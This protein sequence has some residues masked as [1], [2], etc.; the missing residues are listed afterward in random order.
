MA[1]VV[2]AEAALGALVLV[3]DYH[4]SLLGRMLAQ[5]RPD[6]HTVHFCHIPFA[7]PNML[8]VLP[9]HAVGELLAGLAG[10]GA[11]GF[12]A[13]RWAEGFRACFADADL[14]ALAGLAPSA[15]PPSFVSSL[16]PDQAGLRD[17][18]ASPA[19]ADSVER[20]RAETGGRR[21]ILRVDRV[22]PSKNI[23]RGMLAFEEL[24]ET[25]PEWI[26]AVVHL[27]L[28]YPSRQ[29]LAD[30]LALEAEVAHVAERINHT[31]GTEA[32]QPIVLHVE[33]DRARSLA[34]LTISDVLLVNPVRD[35]LNLVAKEGPLLNAVDGVL[36]LS[37]EAGVWE[38]L[39]E[40]ALDINPFD[41][42]GTAEA[43]HTALTMAPAERARRAGE[44]TELVEARTAADWLRDQHAA[45]G[46]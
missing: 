37:R 38:E 41:V 3:Q 24:L 36:V 44:L 31:W 34:A 32:W 18:A 35:G 12:H 8:R 42:T 39:A 9:D 46:L 23:V 43:L 25:H 33:D 19:C 26:D 16:T 13:E 30:Y 27:A 15:G 45:A 10:F 5:G 17:E 40:P 4:F 22:E 20:L 21:I 1:D 2:A 7:D 11:C 6:L 14:A 28:V 29:G